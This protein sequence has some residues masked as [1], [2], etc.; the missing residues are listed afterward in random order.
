MINSVTNTNQSV[1]YRV[2]AFNK[3]KGGKDHLWKMAE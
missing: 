3:D 2:K 1:L